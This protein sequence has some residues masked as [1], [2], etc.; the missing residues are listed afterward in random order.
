MRVS[1]FFEGFECEIRSVH[2]SHFEDYFGQ[3]LRFYD[4]P[5]FRML[6]IV[7]PNTAG[8]WPW[9][10]EADAWFRAREPLLDRPNHDALT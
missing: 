1:G 10:T 2:A 3:D 9:D 8:I 4:G 6:Q 7:Y 5:H